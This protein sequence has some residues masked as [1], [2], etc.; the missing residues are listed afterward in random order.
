MPC[1][2]LTGGSRKWYCPVCGSFMGF[3]H[4][5]G[6]YVLCSWAEDRIDSRCAVEGMAEHPQD[7]ERDEVGRLWT[8]RL[9]DDLT[10]H[11]DY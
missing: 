5:P 9:K 8:R 3:T 1:V 7:N 11:A 10:R 4:Q 6:D 2:I